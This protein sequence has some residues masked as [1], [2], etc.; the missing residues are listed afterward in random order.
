MLVIQKEHMKPSSLI[1]ETMKAT[2]RYLLVIVMPAPT[3][4]TGAQCYKGDGIDCVL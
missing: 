1:L 3:R 4:D 2:V